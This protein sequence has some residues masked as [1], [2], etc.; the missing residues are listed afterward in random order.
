MTEGRRIDCDEPG[1][2]P[3]REPGDYGKDSS[4]NWWAKVPAN[5]F[6]GGILSD[7]TVTEHEDGTITVSPSILMPVGDKYRWHGYL[8]RGAWRML[9]DSVLRGDGGER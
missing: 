1:C 5:G 4:G 6:P 7:H 9:G 2:I 8:E 3:I